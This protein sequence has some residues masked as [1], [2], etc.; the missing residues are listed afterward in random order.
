MHT[1]SLPIPYGD[2]D[3]LTAVLVNIVGKG[4]FTIGGSS[5]HQWSFETSKQLN[6]MEL[7]TIKIKMR[8]HTNEL[9]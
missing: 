9:Q 3:L 4:N 2:G 8:G 1:H 5:D 7:E 6:D